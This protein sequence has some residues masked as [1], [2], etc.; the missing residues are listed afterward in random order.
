V[1]A[2]APAPQHDHAGHDHA[3]HDHAGHDH[4]DHDHDHPHD[5]DHDHPHAA[6]EPH[7]HGLFSHTHALPEKGSG[8]KGLLAV[9]LAGGMVPSPS[10]LIVLLGGIAL[11]RAWFGFGLVVA[12]GLGMAAALMATG[13]LLV[14]ARDR[15]QAMAARASSSRLARVATRAAAVLPTATAALVIA[16]GGGVLLRAALLL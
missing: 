2:G 8:L 6:G 13:L 9:G 10:A 5:H 15:V 4:A 12:Y 7:S 16:I 1:P 3:G 11:G 14:R